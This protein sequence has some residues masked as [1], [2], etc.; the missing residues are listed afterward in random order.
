M[1]AEMRIQWMSWR[2]LNKPVVGFDMRLD[3]SKTVG[4]F[5]PLVQRN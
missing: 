1:V 4:V 5:S 3:L 2:F